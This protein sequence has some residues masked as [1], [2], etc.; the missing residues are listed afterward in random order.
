MLTAMH[1]KRIS[2]LDTINSC[3]QT[4]SNN[5]V[6]DIRVTLTIPLRATLFQPGRDI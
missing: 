1:L 2:L 6:L 5:I 4:V 3:D